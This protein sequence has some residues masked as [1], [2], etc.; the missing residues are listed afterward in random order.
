MKRWLN[1]LLVLIL[2]ASFI[3]VERIG[4][5][6]WC[7]ISEI[8]QWFP[9]FNKQLYQISR[10]YLLLRDIWYVIFCLWLVYLF[11]RPAYSGIKAFAAWL[12]NRKKEILLLFISLSLSLTVAEITLRSFFGYRP[13]IYKPNPWF[14]EVDT[15]VE[16]KGFCTDNDGIFKISPE[17]VLFND[18]ITAN[19]NYDN[20]P[21]ET[22]AFAKN[23]EQSGISSEAYMT[24]F[25][26]LELKNPSFQNDFKRYLKQLAAKGNDARDGVD[27]AILQ[28]ALQPLNA[29]GFRSI[30]FQ[31][32]H[33][34]KKSIL[35]L[36][37][38]FAFGHSA[39]NLSNSFADLLLAKGYVVYNTG[40]SGAD[41]AQYLAIAKKYIPLLKPDFVVVNFFL[42]N[43]IFYFKRP[44]I[45]NYPPIFYA[46]NAGNLMACVDGV[47]LNSAQTAYSVTRDFFKINNENWFNRLCAKTVLT[48]QGWRVLSYLNLVERSAVWDSLNIKNTAIFCKKPCTNEDL[49]SIQMLAKNAG[50][51]FILIAIPDMQYTSKDNPHKI[52]YLFEGLPFYITPVK[53]DG[54]KMSDG[55]FNDAGH[56]IHAAFI[57]SI[58]KTM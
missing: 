18:S 36:G 35:V 14:H 52:P 12:N 40:I 53:I 20:L 17:A 34:H 23:Y 6:R 5:L 16:L 26:F 45:P 9:H 31:K 10:R 42:G 27:S 15:L 3:V 39:E 49:D 28:Y 4:R 38:S 21:K 47:C 24:F 2:I 41:P 33:T 30:P 25:D 48:T 19:Y 46:T 58:I 57:D 50:T 7:S 55:H 56:K 43:D 44:V 8:Q 11:S 32:Y 51:K 22:I 29:D 54:Y 1:Y 37:D 13:A